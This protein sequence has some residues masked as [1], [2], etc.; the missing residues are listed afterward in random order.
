[1]KN[2]QAEQERQ[3]QKR[4]QEERGDCIISS[5]EFEQGVALFIDLS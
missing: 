4:L 5:N 1:M 2:A 3:L